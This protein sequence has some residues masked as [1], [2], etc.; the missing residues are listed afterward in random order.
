MRQ[1]MRFLG[2]LAAGI[3]VLALA[4]VSYGRAGVNARA[5]A[6]ERHPRIQA[7][8]HA[9]QAA[10]PDLQAAAHDFCGHRVEALEAADRALNQLQAALQADRAS[11]DTVPIAGAVVFEKANWTYPPAGPER[12]PLIR[13]ALIALQAARGELQHAAHDFK[14]HRVEA[15][16]ATNNAI[17]QLQRALA[18]DRN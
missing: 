5:A 1:R 6:P 14:G 2:L 17:E 9:L 8:I 15:L 12:H 7:A 13:K 16:E 18:C 3:T 11:L 10:R 4:S